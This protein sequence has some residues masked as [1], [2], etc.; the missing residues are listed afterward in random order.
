MIKAR[1]PGKDIIKDSLRKIKGHYEQGMNGVS[2]IGVMPNNADLEA[3][4]ARLKADGVWSAPVSTRQP[5]PATVH[6]KLSEL[7]GLQGWELK[8]RYFDPQFRAG[9]R[10]PDVVIDCDFSDPLPPIIHPLDY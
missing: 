6:L 1:Y 8:Q 9:N 5:C 3:I 4:I 10:Q 7:L 2:F